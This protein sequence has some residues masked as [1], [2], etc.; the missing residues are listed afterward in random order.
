MEKRPLVYAVGSAEVNITDYFISEHDGA[1]LFV[2][3]N[4]A[5]IN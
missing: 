1:E 2:T 4:G 3:E 5:K